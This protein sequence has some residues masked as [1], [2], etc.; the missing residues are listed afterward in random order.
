MK[1]LARWWNLVRVRWL[2]SGVYAWTLPRRLAWCLLRV[3][4][5]PSSGEQF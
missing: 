5:N 4:P 1:A 3:P 2:V